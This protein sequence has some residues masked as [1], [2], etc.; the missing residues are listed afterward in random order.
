MA[1]PATR[2][3]RAVHGARYKAMLERLRDARRRAGLTQAQVADAL[4]KTQTFVSKCE[5]GER[6]IDPIDLVDFANVYGRPVEY[7]L[8]NSRGHSR[9]TD[10][11][12]ALKA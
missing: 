7:F 6:R 3:P 5:L 8:S 9:G 12:T 2:S 4:G 10:P 1:R 11:I